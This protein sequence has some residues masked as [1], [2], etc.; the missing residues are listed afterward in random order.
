MVK[1]SEKE[2]THHG[3]LLVS[4]LHQISEWRGREAAKKERMAEARAGDVKV[5]E[6][7]WRGRRQSMYSCRGKGRGIGGTYTEGDRRRETKNKPTTTMAVR[8][9]F[10]IVLQQNNMKN[11]FVSWISHGAYG[12]LEITKPNNSCGSNSPVAAAVLVVQATYTQ[13]TQQYDSQPHAQRVSGTDCALN[14]L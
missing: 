5:C 1:R 8:V 2:W 14:Y 9:S 10:N 11:T 12:L 6:K 7:K 13:G 3:L 4:G